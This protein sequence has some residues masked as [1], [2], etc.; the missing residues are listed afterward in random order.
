MSITEVAQAF[1]T[2]CETGQGWEA[3]HTFCT[4]DA[5][6][7]AQAHALDGVTALAAYTDWMKAIVAGVFPGA[8][9][10]TEF[11]AA[12][13]ARQRVAAYGIFRATHTGAGGPQP[14][15]GKSAV[16][17]YVYVMQFSGGK[18]SHMTKIWNS[19][20]CFKQLGWA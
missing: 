16:T 12:D 9:Y 2:A 1:F 11:F 18:I 15:T 4:P 6:F 8:T 17:D 3:C 19:E 20:D 14:P 5:S 10:S 13:D 7:A